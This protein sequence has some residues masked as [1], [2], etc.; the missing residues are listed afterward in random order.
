MVEFSSILRW[1]GTTPVSQALP[2]ALAWSTILCCSPHTGILSLNSRVGRHLRHGEPQRSGEQ[3]VPVPIV[4][5]T[6]ETDPAQKTGGITVTVDDPM[7]RSHY[8]RARRLLRINNAAELQLTVPCSLLSLIRSSFR[9][10]A[11]RVVR[12][13]TDLV[14]GFPP[15]GRPRARHSGD[16]RFG[17]VVASDSGSISFVSYLLCQ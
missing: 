5:H 13:R 11:R 6:F 14:A 16:R 15:C 8:P 4:P 1:P 2:R 7:R 9:P 17:S 12:R 10:R 3:H